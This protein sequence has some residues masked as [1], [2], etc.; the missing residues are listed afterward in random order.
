MSDGRG[1]SLTDRQLIS[2]RRYW[3]IA[4]RINSLTHRAFL[5]IGDGLHV[6][7]GLLDQHDA[8][9]ARKSCF[10]RGDGFVLSYAVEIATAETY[11]QVPY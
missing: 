5:A 10:E 8:E 7:M 1:R 6:G 2:H 3:R 11:L 4:P 9:C